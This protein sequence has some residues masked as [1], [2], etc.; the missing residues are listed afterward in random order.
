VGQEAKVAVATADPVE[1]TSF[2]ALSWL[3]LTSPMVLENWPIPLWTVK[4]AEGDG[5]CR[6][7]PEACR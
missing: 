4:V 1:L 3:T 7:R 5:R 6:C 2:A